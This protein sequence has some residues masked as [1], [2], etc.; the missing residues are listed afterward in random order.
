MA[1]LVL[2]LV[3]ACLVISCATTSRQEARGYNDRHGSKT[4]LRLVPVLTPEKVDALEQ[5]RDA[6]AVWRQAYEKRAGPRLSVISSLDVLR[7]QLQMVKDRQNK[8]AHGYQ[9]S[10]NQNFLDRLG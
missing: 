8:Q 10:A 5:A 7:R 1:L 2:Q 3:F 9:A 6:D 4:L